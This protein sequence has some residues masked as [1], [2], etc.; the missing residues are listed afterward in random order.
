MPL[1]VAL[2]QMAVSLGD[3]EANVAR[4]AALAEQAARA[5]SELLLLPELWD[6]GYDLANWRRYAVPLNEGTFA[7]MAQLARRHRLAVGGSALEASNGAAYNTFALYG[8][9]GA[10]LASYRKVH[11]FGVMEE[12]RWL[13]GGQRLQL[14]QTPWGNVGLAICYDLR[15][16]EVFRRYALAGARAVFIVAEWPAARALHWRTL[17]RARAIENSL[18]VLG[19]N[20]VGESRGE[21]FA[22]HSAVVDPWGELLVEGNDAEALLIAALDLSAVDAAHARLP[23]LSDRRPEV[24]DVA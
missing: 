2:A 15:F 11:L 5:G 10:L 8:A 13:L 21:R 3:Q 9:D 14:A 17:L 12:P 16:P 4:A 23:V 22:G 7:V 24:Y 6:T 20:R 1:N 18:F 19:V